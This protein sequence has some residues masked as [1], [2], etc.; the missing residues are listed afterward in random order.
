MACSSGGAAA[1]TMGWFRPERVG[2]AAIEYKHPVA[3]IPY[4]AAKPV[5]D[6]TVDDAEW[7]GAFSQRA[8]RTTGGQISG[9]QPRVRE[10]GGPPRRVAGGRNGSSGPDI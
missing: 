3:V 6:G 10:R 7:Q 8:L 5:I 9:R 4:A 1:L 2:P